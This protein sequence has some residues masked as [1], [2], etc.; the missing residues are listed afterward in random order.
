MSKSV[1]LINTSF[2]PSIGGVENSLRGIAESLI[3]S[4]Y[5]VTIVTGNQSNSVSGHLARH[6]LIFGANV[7]RFQSNGFFR[8]MISCYQLCRELKNKKIMN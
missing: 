5:D 1:L 7:L 2:Y 8:R 4:G 6:E 3:M